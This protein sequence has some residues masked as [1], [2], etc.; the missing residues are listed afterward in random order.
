MIVSGVVVIGCS[1]S[2]RERGVGWN[3]IGLGDVVV[4]CSL[5]QLEAA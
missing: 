4:G 3:L 5:K 2:C 1:L